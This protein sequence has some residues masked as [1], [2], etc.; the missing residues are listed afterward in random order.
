MCRGRLMRSTG[1]FTLFNARRLPN[2]TRPAFRAG[3]DQLFGSELQEAKRYQRL[4]SLFS[5][6]SNDLIMEI[7]PAVEMSALPIHTLVGATR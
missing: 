5:G 2:A 3:L 7:P 1:P 6:E 4:Y